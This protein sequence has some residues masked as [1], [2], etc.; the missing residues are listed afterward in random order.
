[1]KRIYT[2]LVAVISFLSLPSIVYGQSQ[3]LS[4]Y[5]P[6]IEVQTTPPSSPQVPIVVQNNNTENIKLKIELVPFKTDGNTGRV[7]LIPE[8]GNKGF[9]P[10]YKDRIQFLIDGRKTDTVELL[11]L[12]SREIILNINLSKGDPPGDFYYSIVMLSDN[13]EGSESSITRI[14]AGIATNLLLS[15]G[16]KEKA[17]GGIPEFS[18]STFKT[19]GPVNFKLKLHNASSHL[20]NPTGN[21]EITNMLGQKVGN[22]KILPQYILAGSDRYL[23]SEE[24]GSPSAEMASNLLSN[25]PQFTWNEVFLFGFYRATAHVL[26]EENGNTITSTTYF[27]AFPLY[28]FFGLV[29]LLFILI[30]IYLRVKKKI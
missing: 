2:I 1:M 26:L 13:T 15:I 21:I 27:L 29:I 10:Y 3:S 19:N 6:V 9:Y 8:E 11:A 30:S 16:P 28:V 20:I 12:E 25:K 4:I 18:T 23:V 7:I 24:Q 22:I 14:P 5:P 17:Q